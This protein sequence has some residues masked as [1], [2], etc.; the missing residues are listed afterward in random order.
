[1]YLG[2]YIP[3]NNVGALQLAKSTEK[4]ERHEQFPFI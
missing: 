1:M 2:K 4:K 3:N